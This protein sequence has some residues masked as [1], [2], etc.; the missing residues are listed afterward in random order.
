M[1]KRQ[2]K[3]FTLILALTAVLLTACGSKEETAVYQSITN[4][5]GLAMTDTMTL[6]AV[7]DIV[8]TLSETVEVDM[9]T[10]DS[11]TQ[12]FLAAS[13]DEMAAMCNEI[14]GAKC[15]ATREEGKITLSLEVDAT[16]DAILQL[17]ELGIMQIEGDGNGFSL[18]VT[19][20]ALTAGGFTRI[21]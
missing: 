21:D 8:Q 13:Y 17:S 15:S 3:C 4:S 7:D 14:E 12:D 5:D 11:D 20:E 6:Y 2:A 16:G 9:S 1:K 19:D 18:E 10:L